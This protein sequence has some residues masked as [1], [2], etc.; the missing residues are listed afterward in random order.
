LISQSRGLGDV[1]KRQ[2]KYIPSTIGNLV[3]LEDL[4]CY[5]NKLTFLPKEIGNLRNL[6]YLNCCE[7]KITSKTIPKEFGNLVNLEELYCSENRLTF[8]PPEFNNLVKLN[9]VDYGIADLDK[10]PNDFQS[11]VTRINKIVDKVERYESIQTI[12]VYENQIIS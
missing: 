9:Y 12:K 1:Y 10:L 3:N 8:L 4:F 7:N 5:N 2:S 6:K 11:F